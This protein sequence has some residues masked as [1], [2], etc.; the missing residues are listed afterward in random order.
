MYQDEFKH[1]GLY[2]CSGSAN[3][4]KTDWTALHIENNQKHSAKATLEFR[5]KK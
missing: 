5:A 1:A 3:C 2:F 4:C